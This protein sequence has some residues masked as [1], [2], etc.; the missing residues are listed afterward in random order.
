MTTNN[1]FSTYFIDIIK[2]A[3][4]FSINKCGK[5]L[6]EKNKIPHY[7]MEMILSLLEKGWTH[8]ESAIS[9]LNQKYI[10]FK[11]SLFG[12]MSGAFG[13]TLGSSF[14]FWGMEKGMEELYYNRDFVIKIYD[15]GKNVYEKYHI[16]NGNTQEAEELKK[17]T[18]N[19]IID[20]TI[21]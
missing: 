13:T 9:S 17:E 12:M 8:F 15:I 5:T 2:E 3:D 21:H 18:I 11:N 4:H 6:C 16:T 14:A 7:I 10:P 19:R 1:N 20:I